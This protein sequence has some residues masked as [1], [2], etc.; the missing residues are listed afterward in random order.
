[1][2]E[3]KCLGSKWPTFKINLYFFHNREYSN[4]MHYINKQKTWNVDDPSGNG[5]HPEICCKMHKQ[6]FKIIMFPYCRNV[7]VELSLCMLCLLF[8]KLQMK[9]LLTLKK[10]LIYN[11]RVKHLGYQIRSC[12]LWC[13]IW[14]KTVYKGHQQSL[15]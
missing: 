10:L 11:E 9:A 1:M 14:I 12:V 8:Q 13:L 6:T 2:F 5:W 7:P 4:T 15:E 3:L